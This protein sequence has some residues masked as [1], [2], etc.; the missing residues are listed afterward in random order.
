M[1]EEDYIILKHRVRWQFCLCWAMRLCLC[2]VLC[3]HAVCST[4]THRHSP[5]VTWAWT[6]PVWG[7]PATPS[8]PSPARTWRQT[9]AQACPPWCHTSTCFH[10]HALG[11]TPS[12][13]NRCSQCRWKWPLTPPHPTFTV[14][15]EHKHFE[16]NGARQP[17]LQ[18]RTA[19]GKKEGRV[20]PHQLAS[21]VEQLPVLRVQNKPP[22]FER[23][24][25]LLKVIFN[26]NALCK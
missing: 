4:F 23:F 21:E 10:E 26:V 5:A 24:L 25:L 3:W 9:V 6:G 19:L 18:Q 17:S 14:T 7:P 11:R 16:H 12:Q 15:R 2:T 22:L 8:A 13:S 1:C 20:C